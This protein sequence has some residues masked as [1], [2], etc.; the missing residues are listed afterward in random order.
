[1][2]EEKEKQS[3][4][5][6][7]EIFQNHL[8]IIRSY[9]E[10]QYKLK[11]IIRTNGLLRINESCDCDGY[12]RSRAD[13]LGLAMKKDITKSKMIKREHNLMTN[14]FISILFNIIDDL[15]NRVKKLEE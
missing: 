3:W 6:N 14:K 7:F 10:T 5:H 8:K 11:N 12:G 1:M 15:Q 4:E 9:E 13:V 2:S